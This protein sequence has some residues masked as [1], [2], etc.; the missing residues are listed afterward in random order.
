[1]FKLLAI[2]IALFFSSQDHK[3][4]F[5][6]SQQD[7]VVVNYRVNN[8]TAWFSTKLYRKTF[9]NK[10]QTQ[11]NDFRVVKSV[12]SGKQTFLYF[13]NN[14]S[15]KPVQLARSPEYFKLVPQKHKGRAASIG[16]TNNYQKLIELRNA[17]IYYGTEQKGCITMYA[18]K[19]FYN[20]GGTISIWYNPNFGPFKLQVYT[21]DEEV[22]GLTDND[23]KL[24]TVDG[25]DAE[26]YIKRYCKGK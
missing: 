10:G 16:M 23:F 12:K 4:I 22:G 17:F 11:M 24:F 7:T 15:S 2:Y 13:D 21:G 6:N 5:L 19:K 26:K 1:M 18:L 9:S 20:H 3:Y 14:V 8:D 25:L